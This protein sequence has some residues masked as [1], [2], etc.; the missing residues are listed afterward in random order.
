MRPKTEKIPAVG[1][2]GLLRETYMAFNRAFRAELAGHEITFGQFRHLQQLAEKD[3]IPQAELSKRIGI[4]KAESTGVLESM[5]Q[6][7]LITRRR[8]PH[9]RR[10]RLVFLT[11]KARALQPRMRACA[12][13]V[14]GL[15]RTGLT[16]SEEEVL[17]D[18]LDRVKHN[19]T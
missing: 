14:N 12:E 15:A 8:D 4:P 9:D 1:L 19:L 3:G 10:Q 5:D 2:G 17:F 7:D 6:A 11:P 18:L 16:A 13:K